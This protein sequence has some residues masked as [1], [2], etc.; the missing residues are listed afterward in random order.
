MLARLAWGGSSGAG[1]MFGQSLCS[2]LCVQ[3]YFLLQRQGVQGV[4]VACAGASFVCLGLPAVHLRS[5]ATAVAGLQLLSAAQLLQDDIF[6]DAS[7]WA[8]I[9]AFY[10][11][12]LC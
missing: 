4:C 5:I 2:L 7:S 10:G 1:A 11:S 3:G 12:K 8:L 9:L 6:C